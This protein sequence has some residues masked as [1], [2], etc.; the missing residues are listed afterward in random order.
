[1]A[2]PLNP[3]EIVVDSFPTGDQSSMSSEPGGMSE[4]PMICSCF[5]SCDIYCVDN[6]VAAAY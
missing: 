4:P 2:T 3:D 1:M 5:G 6:T